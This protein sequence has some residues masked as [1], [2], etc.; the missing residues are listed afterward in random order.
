MLTVQRVSTIHLVFG[1][2]AFY[3]KM[4]IQYILIMF[5]V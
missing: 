3:N 2:N 1:M 4:Y 5:V